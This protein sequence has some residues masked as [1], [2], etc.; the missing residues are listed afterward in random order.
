MLWGC[1]LPRHEYLL[2]V[3]APAGLRASRVTGVVGHKT[4]AGRATEH[5]GLPVATPEDTW[6][7]L[8]PHLDLDDL[9]AVGDHLIL[10]PRVLDPLDIR[11]HTSTA[12]LAARLAET[13]GRGIRNAMAALALLRQGAE[14]RP[15]SLM[16]RLFE[17]AGFPDMTLQERI[18]D[19]SGHFIGYADLYFPLHRIAVEYDGDHH[20][21]DSRQHDLDTIRKEEMRAALDGYVSIRKWELFGRPQ[22]ALDR[23]GKALRRSGWSR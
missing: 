4:Q 19:A 12:A 6:L 23:V 9:V 3:S 20:R 11:P 21:S 10:N 5:H 15:E 1:P 18:A 8:A 14:S 22:S 16:R 2:H 7:S 13:R 17:R